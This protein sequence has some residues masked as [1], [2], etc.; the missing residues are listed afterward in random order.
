MG[1]LINPISTR[2]GLSSF[3]VFAW[4]KFALTTFSYNLMFDNIIRNLILWLFANSRIATQMSVVGVF[5]SHF[6]VIRKYNDIRIQIYL[7]L[8]SSNF[9]KSQ[10]V[11]I[12]SSFVNF[13]SELRSIVNQY[14]PISV[15]FSARERNNVIEITLKKVFGL[16]IAHL[17]KK[18]L[19]LI[20]N[21]NKH[22]KKYRTV[23]D[24]SFLKRIKFINAN[25]LS[26]FIARRLSFGFE[27]NK[28]LN[29]IITDLTKL[30]NSNAS[31]ILGFKIA[32]SGRF[33]KTQMASYSWEKYGP[34]CL[35]TV[36]SSVDYSFSKVFLKYGSC[37]IKV[38]V[39]SSI[40]PFQ[41]Y[42]TKTLNFHLN[43]Q[44]C[45]GLIQF[46]NKLLKIIF[47]LVTKFIFKAFFL[48][49]LISSSQTRD[50]KRIDNYYR[51]LLFSSHFVGTKFNK[52]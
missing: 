50:V 1:H 15:N 35:S 9:L 17:L 25:F 8:N 31:K 51:F 34:L 48:E 20:F 29:P 13:R 22:F 30:V 47:F 2:L 46:K 5:L 12:E 26:R 52:T 40:Y 10:S 28:V 27:L 42:K 3:W 38:W 7:I 16:Y 45:Y 39:F 43:K 23:F 24:I 6:R 49:S 32:C 41:S 37:G 4:S 18:N 44:F 36:S 11:E 33:N 21:F 19:D 14:T